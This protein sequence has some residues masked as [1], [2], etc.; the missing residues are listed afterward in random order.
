MAT[1]GMQ[2]MTSPHVTSE[3]VVM[4]M[5]ANFQLQSA[6]SPKVE[7]MYRPAMLQTHALSNR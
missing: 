3:M 6:P 7:R 1:D 2:G 4:W 5:G